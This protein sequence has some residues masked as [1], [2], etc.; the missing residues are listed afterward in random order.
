M[1]EMKS[2]WERALEKVEGMGKLTEDEAKRIEH[3]PAGN[4]LAAKYLESPDFDLDAELTKYKGTGARKHILQGAEE[5]FV[6]N[7]TLPYHE[8][9]K[10]ITRRAM[11]GIKILKENKKQLD[12]TYELIENLLNYYE[13]ARQQTFAQ[14]KQDFESKLQS[15]AAALQQKRGN[16]T[17]IEAELQQQFQ[18]EWHKISSQLDAQYEKTLEEHRQQIIKTL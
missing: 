4:R 1:D 7:I 12:A 18:Q 17:S 10:Q 14:F 2:A 8:R 9:A 11:A 3:L 13:Q 6:R 16:A 5:I 15:M